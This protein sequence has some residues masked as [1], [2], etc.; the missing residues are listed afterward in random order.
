MIDF[1]FVHLLIVQ[2]HDNAHEHVLEELQPPLAAQR[3]TT[4]LQ[5]NKIKKRFIDLA[6]CLCLLNTVIRINK[7]FQITFRRSFTIF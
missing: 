7:F 6:I 4:D 1:K 2:L 5:K 3:M